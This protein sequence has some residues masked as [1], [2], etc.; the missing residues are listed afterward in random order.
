MRAPGGHCSL[1]TST[2]VTEKSAFDETAPATGSAGAGFTFQNAV[3][4]ISIHAMPGCFS[5][6]MRLPFSR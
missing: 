5:T 4:S 2:E 6:T 3:T 1:N